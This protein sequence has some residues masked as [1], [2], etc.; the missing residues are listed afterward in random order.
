MV[1]PYLIQ[2]R[3]RAQCAGEIEGV[4]AGSWLTEALTCATGVGG[5]DVT[6]STRG[7]R[8]D[9]SAAPFAADGTLTGGFAVKSAS[10]A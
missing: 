2:L 9:W 8:G 10:A 6:R 5:G 7:L 4:D 1:M 3:M